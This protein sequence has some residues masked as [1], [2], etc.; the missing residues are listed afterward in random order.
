MGLSFHIFFFKTTL[1]YNLYHGPGF[2]WFRQQVRAPD[3]I[4]RGLQ[5]DTAACD[6]YVEPNIAD[7]IWFSI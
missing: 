7:T 1:T 5:G 4:L 6:R 3:F 2:F